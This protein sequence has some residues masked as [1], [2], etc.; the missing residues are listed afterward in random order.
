VRARQEATKGNKGNKPSNLK[1]PF[2]PQ[3]GM[4]KSVLSQNAT[5][6]KLDVLKHYYY[7][8]MSFKVH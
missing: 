8:N 3:K 1:P 7:F 2:A 4:A 5:K 6:K